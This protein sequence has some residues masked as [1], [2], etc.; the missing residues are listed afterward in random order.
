MQPMLKHTAHPQRY[1][2]RNGRDALRNTLVDQA[3]V[4]SYRS[5]IDR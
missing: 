1:W 2:Q 4:E 3:S 5:T